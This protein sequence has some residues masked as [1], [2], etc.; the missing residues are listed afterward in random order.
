MHFQPL[1][2]IDI[3]KL[4]ALNVECFIILKMLRTYF[5]YINRLFRKT[6]HL[7]LYLKNRRQQIELSIRY[8]MKISNYYNRLHENNVFLEEALCLSFYTK[9]IKYRKVHLIANFVKIYYSN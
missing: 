3:K 5:Y 1:N 7:L 8:S 2:Y 4:E 6:V 9:V